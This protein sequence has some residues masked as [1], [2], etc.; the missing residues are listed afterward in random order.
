MGNGT[1]G[2]CFLGLFQYFPEISVFLGILYR[3]F[4]KILKKI[5]KHDANITSCGIYHPVS[6]A[7]NNTRN[8]SMALDTRP[9]IIMGS[10]NWVILLKTRDL[11]HGIVENTDRWTP[12]DAPL[13]FSEHF[14]EQFSV[15]PMSYQ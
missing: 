14:L 12:L 6:L 3:T 10:K 2:R 5:G 9:T 11:L 13:L 15:S 1:K 7:P 4:G 8:I